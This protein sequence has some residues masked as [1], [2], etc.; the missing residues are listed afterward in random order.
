MKHIHKTWEKQISGGV[1][2]IIVTDNPNYL[3]WVQSI[4]AILLFR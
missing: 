2:F 3:P 1:V 4:Y